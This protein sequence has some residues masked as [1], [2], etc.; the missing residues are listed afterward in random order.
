MSSRE[1]RWSPVHI[2]QGMVTFLMKVSFDLLAEQ[3]VRHDLCECM[4]VH[5]VHIL[6]LIFRDAFLLIFSTVLHSSFILSNSKFE[7]HV[8]VV[9]LRR[10]LG[11]YNS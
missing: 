5:I 11:T 6:V 1:V 9:I 4:S 10:P 3:Q 8:L 7:Y 2:V